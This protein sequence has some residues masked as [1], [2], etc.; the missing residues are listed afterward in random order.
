MGPKERIA[1]A[2]MTTVQ[3]VKDAAAAK[4]VEAASAG[5][6]KLDQQTLV[7]LVTLVSSTI[8][9]S[10][11]QAESVLDREISAA[12]K[13]VELEATITT[14]KAATGRDFGTKKKTSGS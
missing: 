1:R 5:V 3:S 2:V 7:Q 13:I 14:A 10:H 6:I 11:R 9:A 4:L 8:E 12:L